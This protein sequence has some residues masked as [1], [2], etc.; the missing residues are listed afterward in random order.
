[1]ANIEYITINIGTVADSNIADS[2]NT[3]FNVISSSFRDLYGSAANPHKVLQTISTFDTY[4]S[5]DM[6]TLSIDNIPNLDSSNFEDQVFS[7]YWGGMGNLVPHLIVSAQGVITFANNVGINYYTGFDNLT[8][9]TITDIQTGD[10][11]WYDGSKWVNKAQNKTLLETQTITTA[12]SEITFTGSWINFEVLELRIYALTPETDDTILKLNL[13]ND[14]GTTWEEDDNFNYSTMTDNTATRSFISSTG[15]AELSL[16]SDTAT[17]G[18]S[19]TTGSLKYLSILL[20]S[21]GQAE[22]S[23]LDATGIFTT[24]NTEFSCIS[25]AAVHE[26]AEIINGLKIYMSSGDIENA[27]VELWGIR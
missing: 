5:A 19:D 8:D 15:A 21:L 10:L 4:R 18:I 2:I 6:G 9:C 27:K 22:F 17:Q 7:G 1:M 11:I 23:R 3:G 13:S 20:H 26:I 25:T 16:I 24:A 12:V 14:S